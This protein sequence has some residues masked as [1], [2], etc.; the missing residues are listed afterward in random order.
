MQPRVLLHVAELLEPAIAVAALVGFLAR[1]H[2]DVLDELVVAGEGLEALLALV[3]LDLVAGDHAARADADADAQ[4]RAEASA[5][6]EAAQTDAASRSARPA[7]R[8]KGPRG[9]GSELARVHLHRVLV[10]EDLRE[11]LPSLVGT[12]VLLYIC[13]FSY[14][15]Y[16]YIDYIFQTVQKHV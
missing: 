3:W 5:D 14:Y 9:R 15:Y 7:G 10:H 11:E 13:L 8:P 4:S 2:P 12:P 6:P 1:V 16:Y